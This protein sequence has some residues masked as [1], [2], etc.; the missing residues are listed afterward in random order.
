MPSFAPLQLHRDQLP[1]GSRYEL[2]VKIASG[3]MAT[4]Y[5][6]R[7]SGAQGFRRLVAIKR[8][9]PHLIEDPALRRMLVAEAHLAAQ[10]H[11]PN[12][13][14]VHDVE[15]LDGEILLIMDYVEG[16]ALS[17][18][19]PASSRRPPLPPQV[20]VRILLDASIGL[21]AA[22]TLASDDGRPLGLVHRDVTPHN[23]LVGLNGIARIADFG[24]AKSESHTLG[25]PHTCTGSLKGKVAYM[26]PEYVSGKPIDARVDVF[27][28]GIM[29]WE[30][31]TGRRLFRGV[32][33]LDS[34]QNVLGF[35]PQPPSKI[36]PALGTHLDDVVLRALVKEP[37]DRWQTA[38][39]FAFALERQARR[40]ELLA[41]HTEVAEH[42]RAVVG[43][44]LDERRA[45]IRA[46]AV[47]LDLGS[48]DA[49]GVAEPEPPP[50]PPERTLT[51]QEEKP[52][53]VLGD[54]TIGAVSAAV[55]SS[56]EVTESA[57]VA[58]PDRARYR[59]R[60]FV[61]LAVGAFGSIG[62]ATW[63]GG[64]EGAAGPEHEPQLETASSGSLAV[65]T[66][67][68]VP[69][70]SQAPAEQLATI[71]S[72]APSPSAATAS[73]LAVESPRPPPPRTVKPAIPKPAPRSSA[74]TA[75]PNPYNLD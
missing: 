42:V 73:T 44:D 46:R 16:A 65:P 51:L 20:A 22:H 9:H 35:E 23:I 24:V 10:I 49:A 36:V 72:A 68:L 4:V 37:E 33:E 64:R 66:P 40:A 48:E 8:A 50:T 2:L 67:T 6:G 54:A 25:T 12:V 34:M 55:R 45:E 1:G 38:Q 71:D 69:L 18:L 13:V 60:A 30:A 19:G 75:P 17:Q 32:N 21:H 28:L 29:A 3:G 52:Q 53:A 11:H 39:D 58:V 14:S 63:L 7:R 43:R 5:V 15:E 27:A 59:R 41:M 74:R 26:A 57:I 61:A 62:V 31:L 56:R 47:R 70:P